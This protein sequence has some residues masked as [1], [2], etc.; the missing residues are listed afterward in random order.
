[1][2]HTNSV[3]H[4][5]PH[6]NWFSNITSY[7]WSIKTLFPSHTPHFNRNISLLVTRKQSSD[8]TQT[9]KTNH[10]SHHPLSTTEIRPY[11]QITRLLWNTFHFPKTE[12]LYLHKNTFYY[13][14]TYHNLFL[15]TDHNQISEKHIIFSCDLQ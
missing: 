9:R 8:K 6:G 3:S 13:T 7:N 5:R 11:R 2:Q 4:H 1:M 12:K 14:N 15:E 10:N